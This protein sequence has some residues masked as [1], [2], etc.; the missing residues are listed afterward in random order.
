MQGYQNCWEYWNC[1]KELQAQCPIFNS[2][3]LKKRR[4]Y[5]DNLQVFDWVRP[6]R[7]F[8]DFIDC[9]WHKRMEKKEFVN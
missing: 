7:D 3:D 2:E 6:R 9:P 1:K 4:L 8:D 5:T